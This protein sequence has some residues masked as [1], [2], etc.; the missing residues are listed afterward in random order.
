MM[1]GKNEIYHGAWSGGWQPC[2][3]GH[4]RYKEERGL[5]VLVPFPKGWPVH[6]LVAIP[7]YPEE[8]RNK[9]S[10]CLMGKLKE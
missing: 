5:E 10:N 6:I 1:E 8:K 3:K 7:I 9:K 2:P 4:S